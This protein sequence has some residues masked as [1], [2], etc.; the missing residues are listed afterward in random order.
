MSCWPIRFQQ[1]KFHADT[2]KAV[3]KCFNPLVDIEQL[4][5][6][7]RSCAGYMRKCEL[8]VVSNA[9]KTTMLSL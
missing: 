3:V 2:I 8:Q 6:P 1:T 5:L 4:R 7:Q 9:H